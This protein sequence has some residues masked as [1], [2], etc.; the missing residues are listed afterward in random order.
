LLESALGKTATGRFLALSGLEL[1][2]YFN[3]RLERLCFTNKVLL[4][5]E[6]AYLLTETGPGNLR[7]D[8]RLIDILSTEKFYQDSFASVSANT[9]EILQRKIEVWEYISQQQKSSTTQNLFISL[10]QNYISN[11]KIIS[12]SPLICKGEIKN[13]PITCL[14][15][16]GEWVLPAPELFGFLQQ[17]Q[18]QHRFPLI[19]AKKIS[20][21]LF[22][23]FKILSILGISLN[24]IYLPIGIKSL[25]ARVESYSTPID[26]IKYCN[27]FF[28]M[29]SLNSVLPSNNPFE[30]F[31]SQTLQSQIYR[32]HD[33][34]VGGQISIKDNFVDTI[35]QI[36]DVK[37]RT[38]LLNAYHAQ[39]NLIDELVLNFPDGITK[40]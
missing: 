21:I 34:F 20:G 9:Q 8:P 33:N 16:N 36:Q 4:K 32:C 19:I 26:K 11:L 7:F 5:N 40:L 27:Q 24:K 23:T 39:Q 28:P 35:S 3:Y 10:L 15:K 12:T 25:L 6:V 22:P 14:I 29:E 38:S 30:Y 31:L 18:S 13:L 37:P 2:V 1:P 17:C